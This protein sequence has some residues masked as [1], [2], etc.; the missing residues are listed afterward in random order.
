[1]FSELEDLEAMWRLRY[2]EEHFLI[3][4]SFG[5]KK[6]NS[7]AAFYD[8]A[9]TADLNCHLLVAMGTISYTFS[10]TLRPG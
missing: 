3:K 1:M 6:K 4:K 10:E 5:L 9:G 7:P 2:A 8:P